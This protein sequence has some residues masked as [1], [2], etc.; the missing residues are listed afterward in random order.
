MDK[1]EAEHDAAATA[2]ML[3]DLGQALPS[4]T[5]GAAATVADGQPAAPRLRLNRREQ[6]QFRTIIPE[7]L[8]PADHQARVVWE[9]VCG[10]DLAPLLAK[11]EAVEGK[12]GRNM[13]DPRI[14]LALWLYATLDGVGR[15]R[16]LDRLC[17]YHA[18]Y[19]WICGEV[20]VNH[21][22]LAEFRS[23]NG[24]FFD[25]LLTSSVAVLR[26]EGLV[27]LNRVAQD[28]MR[29]RAS[30][31]SSSF[32]S[33]GRLQKFEA[34]AKEQ[35]ARLRQEFDNDGG[36]ASQHE[37]AARERAARERL[38]R[39]QQALAELDKVAKAREA[40]KKGDGETARAS[41]TDPEARRM[42]MPD[43]G[44]RPA[45]NA[46]LATDTDSGIIVGVDMVNEGVDSGQLGPMVDQIKQR[47]DAVP[48]EYLV[49][50][51]FV[52]REGITYVA[53][54]HGVTVYAPISA[55]E[56]KEKA[57]KDPFGPAKG[58]SE[59]VKAWRQ[60]M[61][62]A[63]AQQLYHLRAA[64]AEWSNAQ[65]RNR[66]LY[67]LPVRGLARVKA[68]LLLY[69]LAQNLMQGRALRAKA[70]AAAVAAVPTKA[71]SP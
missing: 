68:V 11:I 51:G 28:G 45:Y 25:Q 15:A 67:Q 21:N 46:Q 18:A 5:A 27:D 53:R 64:T 29:V 22:M 38:E 57:G 70:A 19:L 36:A 7:R 42:K 31:G 14:L 9:Y 10:L 17:Q 56:K 59:E 16:E 44:T 37:Q 33:K 26:H 48:P 47:Y 4:P 66:G 71:A 63:A 24:E 6:G 3:F 60:R 41:T 49:D 13:T 61:G 12:P 23:Q 8:L 40:R 1:P 65:A 50:G 30:A 55:K 58:D 62:T 35:V 43:G 39:V 32:R 54:V 2:G 34:E 52:G 20:T 69:A